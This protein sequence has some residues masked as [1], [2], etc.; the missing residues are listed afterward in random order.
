MELITKKI[1]AVPG[2]SRR[3]QAGAR[4]LGI[5]LYA[6]PPRDDLSLDEFETFALDRLQLLRNVENLKV[7]GFEGVELKEKMKLVRCLSS[8]V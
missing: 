8:D 4:L 1:D 3:Q 6:D 2:V 5:T 7:R